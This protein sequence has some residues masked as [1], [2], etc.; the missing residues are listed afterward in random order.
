MAA[1][2]LIFAITIALGL[3]LS[4]V[5]IK[6]VGIGATWI[7]FVGILISHLGYTVDPTAL[8]FIKDFGLILFVFSIG[9]QVG[10]GFFRSF[11]K[12]GVSMNLL[13]VLVVVLGVAVTLAIHYITG[14]SLQ[15]MTGVMSGAITN[16][17]G[18]GAA[19][20]TMQAILVAEGQATTVASQAAA[21]LASPYAVTYPFGVV[22]VIIMI[23][24]FKSIFKIDLEKERKKIEA[25][26]SSAEDYAERIYCEVKNPAIFGKNV[27]EVLSEEGEGI[28][29]ARILKDDDIGIPTPET[30]LEKGDK[31]LIVA[32]KKLKERVR[33]IFGKEIS[34]NLSDWQKRDE[35]NVSKRL[36]ITK[37]SLTGK[38]IGSLHIREAYGV[39]ITRVLRSGV[40]FVARPNMLLQMGDSIQVVGSEGDI[41][42]LAKLVGNKPE[43]LENPNLVPIFAGIA[44]GV[45][46]GSLPIKFPGIPQ[47]IKLGLAGGPLIV[48]ILLG[49]FGPKLRI[50]TYTTLSANKMIREIGINLFMAAVG[51][52]A[53]ENFVAAIVGGGYWW[54]LY[55][56]LI[57]LIPIIITGFIG[58]VFLKF[59]FYQLCGF[60][61]GTHSNPT[62]LSFA[63]EAY[64]TEYTAVNYATVYPFTMFLR[65]LAA[66]VLILFA[67]T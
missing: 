7:L 49:H 57:T 12:G 9:L 29:I 31:L 38:S 27:R 32:S 6:G 16:T 58:R 18:L 56:V 39:T 62:S 17:P 11:R 3:L 54:I 13:A 21:D 30:I 14:E 37:S 5:R 23:I 48:A 26:D 19:Q 51:L 67:F 46:F 36:S 1:T 15:T 34:M 22:G 43:S 61:A 64:G 52:G 59:N 2:I 10:P 24:V 40:E 65:V 47:P 35:H 45:L 20:Q 55:G 8:A 63:Q 41:D 42:R 25:A 28:V 66:Q 50:T 33:I 53:G 60:L 44:L 4:R